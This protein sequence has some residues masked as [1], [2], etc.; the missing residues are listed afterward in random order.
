MCGLTVEAGSASSTEGHSR[1]M[2]SEGIRGVSM[3]R[4][5]GER[6]RTCSWSFQRVLEQGVA[7]SRMSHPGNIVTCVGES[8]YT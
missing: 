3:F 1:A 2:L 6:E 5:P 7:S 8:I 4:S